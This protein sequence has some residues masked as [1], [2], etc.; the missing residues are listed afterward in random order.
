MYTRR[1]VC[2]NFI[3]VLKKKAV[4]TTT[5]MC[6][7]FCLT[8]DTPPRSMRFRICSHN[9]FHEGI[10]TVRT[11]P[12]VSWGNA[13]R[14]L[15]VVRF[16]ERFERSNI[17]SQSCV[18]HTVQQLLLRRDGYRELT[19]C[20]QNHVVSGTDWGF[21]FTAHNSTKWLRNGRFETCFAIK[22]LIYL[23]VF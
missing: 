20:Q 3:D 21:C 19:Q 6:E 10:R 5:L 16:L 9:V 1:T 13:V 11:G 18:K 14:R 12:D 23:H 7:V 2:K 17:R 15:K 8:E 22:N 4:V